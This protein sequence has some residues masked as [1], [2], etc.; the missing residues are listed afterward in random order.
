MGYALSCSGSGGRLADRI[1]WDNYYIE[2]WTLAL[3]LKI[4]AHTVLAVLRPVE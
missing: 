4:L 1:E 2:N 3:D